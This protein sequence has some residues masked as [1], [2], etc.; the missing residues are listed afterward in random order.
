M[1]IR[2]RPLSD[3]RRERFP[4]DVL[5]REEAATISRLDPVDGRDIGV[6]QAREESRLALEPLEPVGIRRDIVGERLERYRPVEPRVMG[7]IDDAH[8]TTGEL[9]LEP[10]GT[11]QV[12]LDGSAAPRVGHGWRGYLSLI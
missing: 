8:A 12:G 5:E 7:E 4:L 1:C 6:A 9:S 3:P 10:V 2:D 11:D